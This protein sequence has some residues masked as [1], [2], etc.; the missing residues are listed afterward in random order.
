MSSSSSSAST[1]T[2]ARTNDDFAYSSDSGSD[3]DE[4]RASALVTGAGQRAAA[5][6]AAASESESDAETTVSEEATEE[7]LAAA[8]APAAALAA[9]PITKPTAAP[10]TAPAVAEDARVREQLARNAVQADAYYYSDDSDDDSAAANSELY[11][12]PPPHVYASA[13]RSPYLQAGAAIVSRAPSG[14]DATR[15]RVDGLSRLRASP[16]AP[17]Q[18]ARRDLL[19]VRASELASMRMDL[20]RAVDEL[21]AATTPALEHALADELLE[22]LTHEVPLG[23]ALLVP[24]PD[25][26]CQRTREYTLVLRGEV[27]AFGARAL[28]DIDAALPAAPAAEADRTARRDAVYAATYAPLLAAANAELEAL[29]FEAMPYTREELRLYYAMML[30]AVLEHAGSARGPPAFFSGNAA[31]DA[32]LLSF[33]HEHERFLVGVLARHLVPDMAT[34]W[35]AQYLARAGVRE[36]RDGSLVSSRDG[37]EPADVRVLER[38]RALLTYAVTGALDGTEPL[39]AVRDTALTSVAEVRATFA[40]ALG[41]AAAA[42]FTGDAARSPPSAVA[43]DALAFVARADYARTLHELVGASMRGAYARLAAGAALVLLARARARALARAAAVALYERT[44]LVLERFLRDETRELRFRAR[45]RVLEPLERRGVFTFTWFARASNSDVERVVRERERTDGGTSDELLLAPALG[46]YSAALGGEYRV[47]VTHR[48][49][50]DGVETARV[51]SAVASVR[52]LDV[53]ERDGVLFD[54]NGPRTF[55]ECAWRAHPVDASRK[56]ART[57]SE[58]LARMLG[59]TGANTAEPDALDDESVLRKALLGRAQVRASHY[60][61]AALLERLANGLLERLTARYGVSA[62]RVLAVSVYGAAYS[63]D[64]R[65]T[66]FGA[67]LRAPRANELAAL[68]ALPPAAELAAAET[69]R[70]ARETREPSW[71]PSR[72][73]SELPVALVVRALHE[74]RASDE[75]LAVLSA[76]DAHFLAELSDRLARFHRAYARVKSRD[77]AD[78]FAASAAAGAYM[79]APE[80]VWRE[81]GEYTREAFLVD[82]RAEDAFWQRVARAAQRTVSRADIAGALERAPVTTPLELAL[83]SAG[84]RDGREHVDY[85]GVHRSNERQPLPYVLA[86]AEDGLATVQRGSAPVG[87]PYDFTAIHERIVALADVYA[88]RREPPPNVTLAM[89]RARAERL[90]VAYNVLAEY[91]LA[92]TAEAGKYIG[93]DEIERQFEHTL[94]NYLKT[95]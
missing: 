11:D 88:G 43:A 17:A 60:A 85:L 42:L 36:E 5:Y 70:A 35:F 12:A 65:S 93:V 2:R 29:T 61:Y 46:A 3:E 40:R 51:H 44:P 76:E 38:V 21:D 77:E 69:A 55:G 89:A 18:Q 23:R 74:A 48:R 25:F 87:T 83:R 49:A 27:A 59:F 82:A 80:A 52:V 75:L 92:D 58:P 24:P 39:P 78:A 56:R 63:G 20:G 94:Q 45:V 53:C 32:E 86:F 79:T 7:P 13:A 90:A 68:A 16:D 95:P 9:A 10:G 14:E 37:G 50:G 66:L 31:L 91:A 73:L 33:E 62:P 84:S 57:A 47:R 34:A 22:R 67:A 41:T 72:S 19:L 1:P 30:D 71:R 64:V 81:L 15:L 28:A 6:D 8:G 54:V 4:D 26:V